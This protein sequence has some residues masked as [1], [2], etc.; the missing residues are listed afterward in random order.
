MGPHDKVT[1]SQN[2]FY[3]LPPFQHIAE[4]RSRVKGPS[5]FFIR[6]Q[7]FPYEVEVTGKDVHPF[8]RLNRYRHVT[9]AVPW[10]WNGPNAFQYVFLAGNQIEPAAFPGTSYPE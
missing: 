5:G 1:P 9:W 6:F 2:L 10:S 4:S 7:V 8:F 3:T